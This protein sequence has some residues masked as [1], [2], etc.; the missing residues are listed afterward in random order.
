PLFED[1]YD[2]CAAQDI[3][4]ESLI[5]EEGVAQVEVNLNHG[6]PL[7]LAD[8]TFLLKRTV[9]HAA[10]KHDIYATFMAKPYEQEPGSAMHVHQTVVDLRRGKNLFAAASGKD[11]RLLLAHIAGLQRHLPA[12]LPLIAPYVN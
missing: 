3:G 11:T 12:A 7:A 4:I 8:Q 2:H 10:L 1:V 6:D 9:R 5:H